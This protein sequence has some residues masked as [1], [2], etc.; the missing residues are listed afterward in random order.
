[1]II[2][3][4][5][6]DEQGGMGANNDLPWPRNKEDMMWFKRVTENQVVV[7]G[8]RTWE[9]EGMP[10][11]LPNRHNVVITHNFMPREDIVQIRGNVIDG[12]KFIQEKFKKEQVDIFVIGGPDILMQART[13]MDKVF[14]TR[15]PGEFFCD[16]S[17]DIDQF[18]NKFKLS[19]THKL[20]TCRI[21]EY[22]AV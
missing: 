16:V 3:L 18:L 20:E 1:M 21:E 7:M 19:Q 5:A 22:E 13:V 9:S 6:V 14:L 2:G 12:L 8:K 10:H 17:I 15:V 11:P 4:F